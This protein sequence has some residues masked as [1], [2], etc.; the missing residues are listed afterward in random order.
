MESRAQ[1][2]RAKQGLLTTELQA[3]ELTMQPDDAIGL[4]MNTALTLDP[5]V[6]QVASICERDHCLR[7]AL[8]SHPEIAEARQ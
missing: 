7:T 5:A 2:L 3:L 1:S 6:R 4:P 8:D